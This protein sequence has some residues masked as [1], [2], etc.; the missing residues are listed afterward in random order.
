MEETLSQEVMFQ[1][2][3]HVAYLTINRPERMN[4]MSRAMVSEL[5]NRICQINDD[6]DIWALIITGAG[7]KAFSAGFDLKEYEDSDKVGKKFRLP[8]T[9][10]DRNLFETMLE[11][12]KPTIAALNGYTLGGGCELS[13]AC[14]IRIAA[15]N[16][17]I[18]LPEAKRGLGCNF[19]S[20]ILHRLIPR[21]LAFHMLYTAEPVTAEQALSFGLV[22]KVVPQ[23]RLMEETE[24]IVR[25][26][27]SNA[28]I[29]L[30]YYKSV[31]VKTWEMPV[32]MAIRVQ[33][34][35][36]PFFSEDREEGVRAFLEKRPPDWK[37]R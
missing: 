32:E 11:C 18:G 24:V 23:E 26:I 33:P 17:V 34:Y 9:G 6:D 22:N 1:V 30:R 13:L 16:T 20:V 15:E 31:A 36:N 12:Y 21:A 37:N 10:V 2:K 28:P 35:P 19:G 8:M 14:D 7:D 3:E 25:K 5:I 29:S 4:A 27:V